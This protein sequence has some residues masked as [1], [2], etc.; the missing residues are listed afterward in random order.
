MGLVPAPGG[1]DDRFDGR[2]DGLPTEKDVRQARVGDQLRR[3]AGTAGRTDRRNRMA[4]DLP[5]GIDYFADTIA[6][7]GAQIDLDRFARL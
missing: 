5:A 4:R 1:F 2:I 7:P 3:I 6:A